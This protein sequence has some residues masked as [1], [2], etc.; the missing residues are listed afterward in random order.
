MNFTFDTYFWQ[1]TPDLPAWTDF[2]GDD[3][4]VLIFAPEAREDA[5]LTAE[6]IA[7][8]QWVPANTAMQKPILL[9]A[10]LAAY[11]GFRQQFFE[12]YNI[13]EN[14]E[15]L[16]TLT[17]VEDL[18]RVMTLTHITVHQISNKGVPYVGY[19]FECAWDEEHALGVLMTGTRVVEIGGADVTSLLWMAEDDLEKQR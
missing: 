7:L 15:H 2:I 11:P 18:P 13:A 6:E 12:D 17:R 8:A 19:Q 3:P 14:E 5:P 10:V 9:D 4:V 16:P 1:A